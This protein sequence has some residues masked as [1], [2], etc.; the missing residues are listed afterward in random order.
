MPKAERTPIAKTAR[1]TPYPY[2]NTEAADVTN[3]EPIEG[4]ATIEGDSVSQ[5]SWCYGVVRLEIL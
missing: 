3:V 2:P 1:A 4:A 5:V